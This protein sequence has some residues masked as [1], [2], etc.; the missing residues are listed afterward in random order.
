MINSARAEETARSLRAGNTARPSSDERYDAEGRSASYSESDTEGDDERAGSN[1]GGNRGR[2]PFGK[3]G[4]LVNEGPELRVA[5][6]EGR[7]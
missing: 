5:L 4:D 2:G 7:R 3:I 6:R 1:G